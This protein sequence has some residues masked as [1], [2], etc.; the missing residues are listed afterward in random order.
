MTTTT[1]AHS[2]TPAPA[3]AFGVLGRSV[4][5]PVL[6]PGDEEYDT[7]VAAFNL[8]TRHRPALV[9]RATCAD[10]IVA[11]IRYARRTGLAVAVQSTGHGAVTS[12]DERS[13]LVTTSR[14][15]HLHVDPAA[16]TARIGAGLRWRPVID[17]A[18]A[19]RLAP[20]SGSSSGVG[21]VGYTLGGGL[22]PLGRRYGFAADHVR[23]LEVVTGD[24]EVRTVTA[25][26]EPELFWGLRGGKGNFGI[27]TSMEVDLVPVSTLYGG[28]L[29][30][31]GEHAGTVLRAWRDWTRSLPEEM[32]T[33]MALLRLPD[34]ED[35]PPPLRG[36]LSVH[37]R[38]AY[39]GDAE[40]GARLVAPMRAA[41]PVLADLVRE[42]PFV[43][44]DSIH[45]DPD[46]PVPGWEAGRLLDGLSDGSID[47]LLEVA[48]PGR[49][50]PLIM[51]ELRLL[52]GALGRPAAVP[53]AVAGRGGAFSVFVLGPAVPGL[54]EAVPA[55]GHAALDALRADTAAT[56]L[57]NFLGED[58]SPEAVSLAWTDEDR[59]R[60]VALKAR[61]DPYNL[62]RTGHAL[63]PG[64]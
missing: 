60:L 59:A 32:S 22:G 13:L 58:T 40:E 17:A 51:V 11:A 7:E 23:S 24:G 26:T 56:R 1:T 64:A 37:L 20:L 46:H 12:L 62:F 33:S 18:A 35:V 15:Q 48:G 53:N 55:A 2:S 14:L 57:V 16:R 52:G 6:L 43:E 29:F 5:L 30:Y 36:V 4:A 54:E 27:V 25:R 38:V 28:G 19:Y 34:H 9:V 31:A 42:M 3:D 8:A 44:S 39:C 61:Y 50:V 21:A 10:D 63:P 49:Q 41:A 45:Q 47:R